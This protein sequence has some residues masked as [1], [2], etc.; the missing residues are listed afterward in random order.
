MPFT[1]TTTLPPARAKVTVHFA[2][3]MMLKP[4]NDNTCEIGIHR[5]SSTHSFQIVLVVSK[6]K[7]PPTLIRLVTG[8]LLRPFAIEVLP[9]PTTGVQVFARTPEPFVRDDETNDVRDFRWALN[10]SALHPDVDFNDGARPVAT[11]NGGVLF[12]PNLTPS[13]LD[14]K[15]VRGGETTLLHRMAADL[16]AAIRLTETGRVVLTWDQLGESKEL[17][18]P[19]SLD[20]EGTTYT[21]SF[22]NNPP[23]TDPVDHDEMYLYYRV[24]EIGGAR[25]PRSSQLALDFVNDD[26]T[27]DEI[28]CSPVFLNP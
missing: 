23:I 21:I 28:P 26:P 15:L 1:T 7:R 19:R 27:T 14:P 22:L 6:P 18:L 20:P 17:T 12:T 8:P 13:D 25:I 3:L 16:A 10:L 2:G 5:F 4:G 24:L 11:L 9:R